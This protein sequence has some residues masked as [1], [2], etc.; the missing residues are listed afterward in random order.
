MFC[1]GNNVYV[2][3]GLGNLDFKRDFYLSAEEAVE[4]G[5]V[6]TV[7]YP[8]VKDPIR[9]PDIGFGKFVSGYDQVGGH[10][11]LY[12]DMFKFCIIELKRVFF[13]YFIPF[14]T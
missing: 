14:Y 13:F 12:V 3:L 1:P 7:I 10:A 2:K 11:C 5:A 8:G 4:Y 9:F 6:D